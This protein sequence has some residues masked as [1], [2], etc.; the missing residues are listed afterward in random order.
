MIKA[1]AAFCTRK[2]CEKTK[3]LEKNN[4]HTPLVR[5]ERGGDSTRERKGIKSTTSASEKFGARRA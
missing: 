4:Q 3:T 2:C 5:I 1:R